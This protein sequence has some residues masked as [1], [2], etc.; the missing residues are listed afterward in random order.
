MADERVTHKD[1][2]YQSAE[3]LAT[4]GEVEKKY[5]IPRGTLYS[6]VANGT[7]PHLRLGKR[8]VRFRLSEL[9]RWLDQCSVAPRE[10]AGADANRDD[11]D[12]DR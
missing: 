10:I 1:S 11:E 8:H 7:I 6:M 12:G 3:R 4:Y 5:G 9:R 2:D